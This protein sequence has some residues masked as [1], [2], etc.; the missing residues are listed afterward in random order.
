MTTTYEWQPY[1]VISRAGAE[2]VISNGNKTLRRHISHTRP[3]EE[4]QTPPVQEKESTNDLDEHFPTQ[5]AK[6]TTKE[7][8]PRRERQPPVRLGDYIRV[9]YTGTIY[10]LVR[11]LSCVECAEQ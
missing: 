8:R 6:Q 2:V 3:Y 1:N 7:G 4:G 11:V 9:L 10:G 5:Q